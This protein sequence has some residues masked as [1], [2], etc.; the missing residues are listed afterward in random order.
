MEAVAVIG[1]GGLIA[2]CA[3]VG[4]RL[5]ALGARSRGLPELALGA[6]YLLFGALGYPLAA[7]ARARA[8]QG[9]PQAGAWLAAALL[10]Q[11]LGVLACYAFN[12][13]V[14]RP[15]RS[16][17]LATAGA[18]LLFAASWI[19]H[20]VDPGWAGAGSRGAWYYTGLAT[21]AAAFVWGGLEAFGHWTRMRRRLRIGLA[22]PVVAD[23]MLLW[24]A[25]SLVI[26]LGFAVFL[27]GKLFLGDNAPVV[28]ACASVCGLVAA[29]AMT[30]AFFPPRLYLRWRGARAAAQPTGSGGGTS[31][32]AIA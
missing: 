32:G 19:G 3:A 2:S 30:L 15:G 10:V 13:R 25:N 9:D 7:F 14:F 29:A 26:A 1:L 27:A 16:G 4:A 28:V 12:W 8:A 23:R 31:G 5:V 24:A 20:G 21:R 17:A 18:G 6:S 11:N 22:D